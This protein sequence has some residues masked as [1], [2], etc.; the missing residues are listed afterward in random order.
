MLTESWIHYHVTCEAEARGPLKLTSFEASLGNIA[1]LSQ[2]IKNYRERIIP[3]K[4]MTVKK[5]QRV[6]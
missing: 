4:T 6:L 3:V 5:P 1:R 2:K